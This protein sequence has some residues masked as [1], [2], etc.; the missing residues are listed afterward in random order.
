MDKLAQDRGLANRLREKANVSGRI[1]ESLNP[2]FASM[3]ERLRATDEKVRSHADQIKNVVRAAKSHANRRDYLSSATNI[4]TFHERCR[5]ISAELQKFIASVDMKHY[6]FLLDQFDDEQKEQLFGYDPNKEINVDDS[7]ANEVD[8]K[9]VTAALKKQAG[10]S[11]WWFNN[12]TDPLADLAHNV[13]TERGAAMRALEKRFSI[14]FLKDLKAN[15]QIMVVRTQKFLQFLLAIFKKL[16]VALAKRNVDRYVESAKLFIKKFSETNGYHDRFVKYYETSIVPLKQQQEKLMEAQRAAEEA[17]SK[18]M[19]DAAHQKREQPK[20]DQ[21]TQDKLHN[22]FVATTNTPAPA[23]TSYNPSSTP[24]LQNLREQLG[25]EEHEKTEEEN[26]P[27]DLK[28]SKVAF[29]SN[30]EKIANAKSLMLEILAYSEELEDADP[31]S[32]L[33]LI[34]IAEGMIDDYKKA[35]V[36]D[37]LKSKETQPPAQ[38]KKEA[39]DPLA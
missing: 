15:T 20:L 33:K 7:E 27:I 19:E 26:L 8:D 31:I 12:V 25:N 4:S 13:T 34:A 9:I 30:I 5:F 39:P 16:A 28:K 24:A 17:K 3:M 2:E 22:Q 23:T 32:S 21:G 1:L 38:P 29:I 14:S 11:D 18:Q 10:L 36:F 37:F 6:K 35:G